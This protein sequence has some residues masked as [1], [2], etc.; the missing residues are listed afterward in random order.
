[1][2][3][4][5]W[6]SQSEQFTT[7]A[8]DR[9]GCGLSDPYRHDYEVERDFEDV[10]AVVDMISAPLDL[11][12]HSI[13]GFCALHTALLTP[14][15]RRLVLY[16]PPLGGPEVASTEVI[17]RIEALVAAVTVMELRWFPATRSSASRGPKWNSSEPHRPGRHG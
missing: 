14:H 10:A 8:I 7:Y 3:R 1:M 17:D 4:G 11:V 6:S 9:R 16:E 2:A 15:V 12:G 13:G 5:G